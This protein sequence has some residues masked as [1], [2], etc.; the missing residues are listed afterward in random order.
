[1]PPREGSDASGLIEWRAE[2]DSDPPY[3][4]LIDWIRE[5]GAASLNVYA[6]DE[7]R[8]EALEKGGWRHAFSNFEIARPGISERESARTT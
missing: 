5:R 1:M 4:D 6:G 3:A 8:L 7:P 2:A